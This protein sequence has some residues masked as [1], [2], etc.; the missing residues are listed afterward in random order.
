MVAY[1]EGRLGEPLV[2]FNQVDRILAIG[3]DRMMRAIAEARHG[4]L[5]PMLKKEHKAFGSI[6]SP[7]Q[8]MMKEICAQCLQRHVDP[9][10]GKEVFF[11]SC[12][13][14]D[15]DLDTVVFAHLGQR[16]RANDALE[17]LANLWLDHLLRKR[18]VLN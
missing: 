5:A 18:P 8:C 10:T 13:N 11:F 14:Q 2:P 12:S 6:N 3:S 16:L 1:A 4:V 17:K 15:Q 9:R 7:M